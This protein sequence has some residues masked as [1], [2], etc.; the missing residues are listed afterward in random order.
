MINIRNVT[1]DDARELLDIYAPYIEKT[2][3]TFEYDV[4]TL[5]EFRERISQISK[6]YP[7]LVASDNGR[8]IGYAYAS[9]FKARAA[10]QW[11]VETSIYLDMK[12]RHHGVGKTLYT[13][14]E[15][16]LNSKGILNMNACITYM[17]EADE[18]LPL[19]SIHFHETMG[20]ARCAH[21]HQIGY[22]F[23]RW[24]DMIWMEKLIGNHCNKGDKR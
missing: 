9:E 13:E 16:Q 2:A 14:L 1:S 12:E 6:S 10:Y 21:F 23:N 11:S 4:P 15:K 20:F 19:D 24:Y 3:I 17:D 22:K 18:Y 5:D 8:I 7:Y